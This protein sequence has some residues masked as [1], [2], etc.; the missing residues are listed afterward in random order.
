MYLEEFCEKAQQFIAS[1]SA[2]QHY[3]TSLKMSIAS[4]LDIKAI[5]SHFLSSVDDLGRICKS[6]HDSIEF[7][8]HLP[9]SV[10]PYLL[11]LIVSLKRADNKVLYLKQHLTEEY[12]LAEDYGVIRENANGLDDNCNEIVTRVRFLLHQARFREKSLKQTA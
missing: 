12:L 5:S 2:S 7:S 4:S 1:L 9:L 6:F 8:P 3:L 10:V 11:P